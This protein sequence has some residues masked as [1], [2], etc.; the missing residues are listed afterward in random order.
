M[1]ASSATADSKNSRTVDGTSSTQSGSAGASAGSHVTGD[2]PIAQGVQVDALKSGGGSVP[3]A[4]TAGVG[5][6]TALQAV[7][8]PGGWHEGVAGQSA[9]TV[10][11]GAGSGSAH[12]AKAQDLPASAQVAAGEGTAASGINSAKLIQTMGETEMHVGMRSAEFGDISIR[13]SLNQQQMVAQISLDHS[14]LSQTI[15]SHLSTMQT[16]LG[17]EYGL[18]ASIEINNQGAPLS[19]GQGDSQQKHQQPS[20][21]SSRGMSV[22]PAES[23]ESVAGV[24]AQSSA[25]SGHGL[26]ITV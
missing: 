2:R 1:G 25:G 21:R 11:S 13:T 19:G 20:G 17:E 4:G 15:S 23:I 22:G 6:Q 10:A 14:D 16:K 3:S 9:T 8:T 24:V 18:H 5:A 26:D 7:L 12:A